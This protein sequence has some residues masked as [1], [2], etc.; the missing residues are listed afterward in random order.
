MQFKTSSRGLLYSGSANLV[1]IN[2]LKKF[3]LIWHWNNCLKEFD[4]NLYKFWKAFFSENHN[5]GEWFTLRHLRYHKSTWH[6]DDSFGA[7]VQ[8][9]NTEINFAVI[10]FNLL[11]LY[12]IQQKIRNGNLLTKKP[13]VLSKRQRNLTVKFLS[14]RCELSGN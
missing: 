4:K 1:T 3:C 6:I 8:F 7:P 9:N 14:K 13:D 2:F 11:T 5:H 10:F 12:I